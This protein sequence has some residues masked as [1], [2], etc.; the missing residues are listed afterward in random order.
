MMGEIAYLPPPRFNFPNKFPASPAAEFVTLLI[1]SEMD[2][3]NKKI[4]HDVI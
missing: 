1:L 3:N 4:I 2:C